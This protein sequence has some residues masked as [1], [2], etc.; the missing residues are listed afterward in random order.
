VCLGGFECCAT[1]LACF[2]RC[3]QGDQALG[4]GKMGD[5]PPFQYYAEFVPEALDFVET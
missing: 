1:V 5:D 2:V 4:H 3:A